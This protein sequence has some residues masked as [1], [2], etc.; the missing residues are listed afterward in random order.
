MMAVIIG[1][2]Q[3]NGQ[4]FQQTQDDTAGPRKWL[5]TIVC[6]SVVLV[7][8][9]AVLRITSRR[10]MR[11]KIWWDDYLILITVVR[12]HSAHPCLYIYISH[13]QPYTN[14]GL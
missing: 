13:S 14:I 11:Q 2:R 7:I 9:F 1:D 12:S 4:Q 8:L 5:L 10:L 3:M 6:S